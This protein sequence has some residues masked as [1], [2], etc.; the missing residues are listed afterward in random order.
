MTFTLLLPMPRYGATG[1]QRGP[2]PYWLYKK[3]VRVDIKKLIGSTHIIFGSLLTLFLAPSNKKL[4]K[5]KYSKLSQ[6]ISPTKYIYIY[7]YNSVKIIP[8]N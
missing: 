1:D 8:T 2:S 4:A 6:E 3:K 7:I 5:K